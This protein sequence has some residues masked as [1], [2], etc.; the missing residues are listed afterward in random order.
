MTAKT[1]PYVTTFDDIKPGQTIE[2][3]W[4]FRGVRFRAEGV[5]HRLSSAGRWCTADGGVVAD[6][7][8]SADT[9]RVLAEPPKPELPTE[10]G[11]VI[12][13]GGNVWL[14]DEHGSWYGSLDRD[15]DPVDADDWTVVYDPSA[16][17][18][19]DRLRELVE[20]LAEDLA[21]HGRYHA[22]TVNDFQRGKGDGLLLAAGGL[23][24]VLTET[25]ADA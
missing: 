5:V 23:R 18:D 20:G 9:L 24:N 7:A 22:G 10:P 4:A 12:L 8:Y 2:R 11:T 1:P 13:I 6:C 15:P 3:E 16:P 17:E 25:R 14:L 21:A 19:Y